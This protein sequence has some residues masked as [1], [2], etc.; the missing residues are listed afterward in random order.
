[1]VTKE[2]YQSLFDPEISKKNYDLIC[3]KVESRIHEIVKFI[4]TL[5]R[6]FDSLEYCYPNG[7]LEF[8]NDIG[9]FEPNENGI[10][11]QFDAD[12]GLTNF[13]DYW[14]WSDYK[15][16]IKKIYNDY[17]EV[18]KKKMIDREVTINNTVKAIK[19]KLTKEEI[20]FIRQNSNR[21]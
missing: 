6:H 17:K 10:Q 18:E 7:G 9:Y 5:E 14:L 19:A 13:N 8:E 15:E 4:R 2:E 12:I 1:M 20:Q 3:S 16:E 21:F 11:I